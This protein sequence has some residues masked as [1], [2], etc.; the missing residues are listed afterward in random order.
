MTEIILNIR[1]H[2]LL[3]LQGFQGYGYSEEFVRNMARIIKKMELN[4]ELQIISG[5]D[6][7]CS[8][9]PHQVQGICQK[10]TGSVPEMQA[11]DR[12]VL[13]HLNLQEGTK[14]KAHDFISLANTRLGSI[15]DIEN[16][17][18]DCNWK[19]KCLWFASRSQ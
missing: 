13:Q 17:C 11:L 15:S 16:I 9:C 3:C 7:I 14:G 1:A 12:R 6:D 2:H 4:S 19:E 10:D 5:C 18:G 8:C